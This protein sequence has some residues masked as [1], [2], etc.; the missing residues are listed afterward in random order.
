MIMCKITENC[1]NTHEIL[2]RIGKLADINLFGVG[3]FRIRT[4][5]V[6]RDNEC[7][8]SCPVITTYILNVKP[9]IHEEDLCFRVVELVNEILPGTN[10]K[11]TDDVILLFSVLYWKNKTKYNNAFT[12]TCAQLMCYLAGNGKHSE[13][14][15]IE[16]RVEA[17]EVNISKILYM[18]NNISI[19]L[20]NGIDRDLETAK[21]VN[22]LSS[23]FTQLCEGLARVGK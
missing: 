21:A 3:G 4:L 2:E 13:P 16:E 1:D 6:T 9:E 18:M 22:M 10:T 23:R 20:N 7:L 5:T 19:S 12:V 11:L 8:L 14:N 15:S 17:L